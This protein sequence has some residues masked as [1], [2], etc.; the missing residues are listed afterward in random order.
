MFAVRGSGIDYIREFTFSRLKNVQGG[1]IIQKVAWVQE[2]IQLLPLVAVA[3]R[4][5][6]V[7]QISKTE[8]PSGI[9][10]SLLA[11]LHA[12]QPFF[13][14]AFV[15]RLPRNLEKFRRLGRR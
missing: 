8:L 7:L 9:V 6:N 13:P 4:I 2:E 5:Q 14:A 12:K 3:K 10:I 1:T 15:H 11:K